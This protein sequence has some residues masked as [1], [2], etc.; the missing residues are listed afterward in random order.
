MDGGW[1]MTHILNFFLWIR[2]IGASKSPFDFPNIVRNDH[3]TPIE[4]E[5]FSISQPQSKDPPQI[6][7]QRR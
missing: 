2:K 4:Q 6:S 5:Q 3:I 1:E 7:V